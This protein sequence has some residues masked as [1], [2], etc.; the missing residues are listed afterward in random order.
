MKTITLFILLLGSSFLS[1]SQSW[2]PLISGVDAGGVNALCVDTTHTLLYV[3]GAFQN[4][5]GTT[6]YYIASWNG[7]S[8][9][10]VGGG[11]NFQILAL[12][13][14]NGELYAGG[15]FNFAGGNPIP[16]LAKWNGINWDPVSTSINN[17]VA[18]LKVHDGALYGVTSNNQLFR[19]DGSNLNFITGPGGN[20]WALE[21]YNNELIAGG[22]G[23]NVNYI[24]KWDGITWSQVGNGFNAYVH[25]L[26]TYNG[27]LYA[28]GEFTFSGGNPANSIARWDGANWSALGGGITCPS[29]SSVFTIT[30][31]NNNIY[32]GGNFC[33][34]GGQPA[35]FIA[36]WNGSIWSTLGSGVNNGVSALA[37][38]KNDLYEAGGSQYAG[39]IL[40]NYIAKW[41]ISTGIKE[42]SFSGVASPFPNP[43]LNSISIKETEINGIITISD[44][45]GK[46]VIRQTTSANETSVNTENIYPG[47]YVLQYCDQKTRSVFKVL[48]Q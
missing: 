4:A 39:G 19:W 9:F 41:G 1:Y 24:A 34:A 16:Y 2:S 20:I 35:S 21:S 23:S 22:S 44:L 26:K 38:F 14:Y 11:M 7:S 27:Y 12:E 8:W 46:E 29:Y 17:T 25:S 31:N 28:G 6:A 13:I 42:N 18:V 15:S 43:F 30:G 48:K 47:F 36:Q 5:S 33:Q 40:V 45:S 3:G 10:S 37:I 32:V